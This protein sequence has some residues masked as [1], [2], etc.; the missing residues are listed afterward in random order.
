MKEAWR[1][2]TAVKK[3]L[4]MPA[5][6]QTAMSV[7]GDCG[8]QYSVRQWR[9]CYCRRR[10]MQLSGTGQ[11]RERERKR[12]C[13]HVRKDKECLIVWCRGSAGGGGGAVL[14]FLYQLYKGMAERTLKWIQ[15]QQQQQQ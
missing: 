3:S 13:I 1:L 2:A 15:L 10:T 8:V 7:S 5:G 11:D 9:A 12:V 4:E 14:A 6:T